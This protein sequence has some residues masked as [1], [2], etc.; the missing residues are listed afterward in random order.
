MGRPCFDGLL[1]FL[2]RV[3]DPEHMQVV[4]RTLEEVQG[5][6]EQRGLLVSR[7]KGRQKRTESKNTS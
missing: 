2:C 4:Q 6:T 5:H 3:F 7:D 1:G